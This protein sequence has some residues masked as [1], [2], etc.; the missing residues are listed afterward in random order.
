M[1]IHSRCSAQLIGGSIR[2]ASNLYRYPTDGMP[3]IKRL[4]VFSLTS[5]QIFQEE[6]CIAQNSE[7]GWT[8][9][10]KWDDVSKKKGKVEYTEES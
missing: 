4:S 1:Y 2:S 5:I 10:E 8:Y 7:D 6:K 3:E 9:R